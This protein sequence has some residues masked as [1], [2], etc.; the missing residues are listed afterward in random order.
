MSCAHDSVYQD[1][2][3]E[4]DSGLLSARSGSQDS[5]AA[6]QSRANGL[7][8][9]HANGNES[10]MRTITAASSA[11]SGP[12]GQGAAPRSTQHSHSAGQPVASEPQPDSTTALQAGDAPLTPGSSRLAMGKYLLALTG[13]HDGTYSLAGL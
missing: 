7:A 3:S 4:P 5:A 10:L 12:P 8:P 2:L 13:M 9:A 1:A 11:L 6:S